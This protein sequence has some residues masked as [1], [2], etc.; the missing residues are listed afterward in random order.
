M[1]INL[2]VKITRKG[3]HMATFL[4]EDLDGMA[5]AVVFPKSFTKL[6]E[7]ISSHAL[8]YITGRVDLRNEDRIQ[9]VV[10]N[11]IPLEKVQEKIK[12]SLHIDLREIG[13]EDS[14]LQ[15]LKELLTAHPGKC[16]VYFHV[17]NGSGSKPHSDAIIMPDIAVKADLKLI[18]KIE[19]LLGDDT[20]YFRPE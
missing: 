4:L 19:E 15:E 17:I 5:Q 20:A 9:I 8:V 16:K 6:R 7:R 13:L 10:E 14:S 2:S 11:I 1:I 3:D 18:K 12:S